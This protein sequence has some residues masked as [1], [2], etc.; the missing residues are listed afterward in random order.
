[1]NAKIINGVTAIKEGDT[2]TDLSILITDSNGT[3]VDLSGKTVKVLVGNASGKI[4]ERTVSLGPETGTIVFGFQPSDVTGNGAMFLEVHVITGTEKRI[5]PANGYIN[6]KIDKNLN[7]VGDVVTTVTLDYFEEQIAS[8]LASVNSALTQLATDRA[9]QDARFVIYEAQYNNMLNLA[10]SVNSALG[11]LTNAANEQIMK[12]ALGAP[13][14]HTFTENYV[15]KVQGSNVVNPHLAGS[16]TSNS[17]IVLPTGSWSEINAAA[18]TSV[19]TLNG[20]TATYT[21]ALT[22]GLRAQF[23]VSFDLIEAVQRKYNIILNGSLADKVEWL[24]Q[25]MTGYSFE[26]NGFG[27]SA[28][29]NKLYLQRWAQNTTA[30]FGSSTHTSGTVQLLT[31]ATSNMTE[32]DNN[33][34][35]HFIAYADAASASVASSV[36]IDFFDL[37][38]TCKTAF[39]EQTAVE[40]K[41]NVLAPPSKTKLLPYV[42]GGDVTVNTTRLKAM[43]AYLNTKGYGV[44]YFPNIGIDGIG[45]GRPYYINDTLLFE[46]TVDMAI[47]ITI[48]GEDYGSYIQMMDDTKPLLNINGVNNVRDFRIKNI[49]LRGGTYGLRV[50]WGAYVYIEHV[51]IRG[52]KTSCLRFENTFGFLEDVWTFHTSSRICESTGNGHIRWAECTLGE[53]AGGFYVEDTEMSFN[54][55]KFLE[56]KTYDTLL[57]ETGIG[58]GDAVVGTKTRA[59]FYTLFNVN[60]AFTDCDFIHNEV[61]SYLFYFTNSPSVYQFVNCKW[62]CGAGTSLFAFRNPSVYAFKTGLVLNSC[63]IT[64]VT[65]L[66]SYA[67]SDAIL[68]LVITNSTLPAATMIEN[69]PDFAQLYEI[70]AG[71]TYT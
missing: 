10:A 32:I 34:F 28:T 57:T 49:T 31:S 3:A 55:C 26:L 59:I 47:P 25:N 65:E 29:G 60:L 21:T 4:L 22:A 8:Q 13:I 46:Y 19:S 16:N 58:G 39:E 20:V 30:W 12:A 67:N 52:C 70:G 36:R 24:R 68:N 54:N 44:L 35:V 61:E 48:C 66:Y 53:D 27:T 17:S 11:N 37:D 40:Y 41:I 15:G 63:E 33:G 43:I 23:K 1:M 62:E 69:D 38:V 5:F 56:L 64:G 42:I 50:R 18:I 6:L 45:S 9:A 2:L 14:T 7:A 71:C 51:S